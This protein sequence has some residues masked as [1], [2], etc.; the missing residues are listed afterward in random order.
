MITAI[1][2][3]VVLFAFALIFM[4]SSEKLYKETET[5]AIFRLNN[6]FYIGSISFY[7][8]QN[9]HTGETKQVTKEYFNIHFKRINK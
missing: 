8:M 4:C 5:G 2:C 1:M 7:D 6:V 9:V 3:F